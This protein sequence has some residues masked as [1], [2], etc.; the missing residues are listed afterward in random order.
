[1]VMKQCYRVTH[2]RH[3]VIPRGE[4]GGKT[5]TGQTLEG[6]GCVHDINGSHWSLQLH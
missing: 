6:L 5:Q 4:K 3:F 1:M 2:C